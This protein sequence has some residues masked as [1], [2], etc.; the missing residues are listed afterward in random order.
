M[1]ICPY[2]CWI[3]KKSDVILSGFAIVYATNTAHNPFP[4]R[5]LYFSARVLQDCIPPTRSQAPA[6]HFEVFGSVFSSKNFPFD[7]GGVIKF[8]VQFSNA[9][10]II[11]MADVS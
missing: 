8:L 7:A 6:L 11:V 5:Q 2:I 10:T 3:V 1:A 4:M 9:K